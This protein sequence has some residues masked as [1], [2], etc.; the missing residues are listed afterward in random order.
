MDH[1][2]QY[3]GKFLSVQLHCLTTLVQTLPLQTRGACRLKEHAYKMS[4]NPIWYTYVKT[5]KCYTD[6]LHN[7]DL[8][9]FMNGSNEIIIQKHVSFVKKLIKLQEGF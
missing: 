9:K 8:P 4:C 6:K 1:I 3:E 5:T 2:V 7:K